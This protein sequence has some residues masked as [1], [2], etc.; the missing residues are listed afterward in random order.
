MGNASMAMPRWQRLD[1]N[2]SIKTYGGPVSSRGSQSE[3]GALFILIS[4]SSSL[5]GRSGP[6]APQRHSAV[7]VAGSSRE[8]PRITLIGR[9]AA[10]RLT[11]LIH[12]PSALCTSRSR[13]KRIR[14][15]DA[16]N[17]QSVRISRPSIVL[18]KVLL[19]KI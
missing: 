13:E 18:M 8:I 9:L 19:P 2:V 15:E 1:G 17:K 5:T 11:S 10:N 16:C 6:A 3:W 14:R 7:A 12:R 4:S